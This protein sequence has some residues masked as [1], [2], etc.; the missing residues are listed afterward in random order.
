[1]A[2]RDSHRYEPGQQREKRLAP[3]QSTSDEANQRG[4][5]L[6]RG[7][8]CA[9]AEAATDFVRWED[10]PS[11]SIADALR[12]TGRDVCFTF[13]PF[14]MSLLTSCRAVLGHAVCRCVLVSVHASPGGIL[15]VSPSHLGPSI[16]S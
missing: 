15:A 9:S 3:S 5:F 11:R 10:R 8:T 14:A 7:L 12:A 2:G 6:P 4:Y 13:E 16:S 1:M